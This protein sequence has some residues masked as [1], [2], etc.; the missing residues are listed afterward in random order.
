M[1][2]AAGERDA[3]SPVFGGAASDAWRDGARDDSRVRSSGVLVPVE[4]SRRFWLA[5]TCAT[6][7]SS[8]RSPMPDPVLA[9]GDGTLSDARDGAASDARD[10]AASD[11]RDGAASDARGDGAAFDARG[12][13]P[14]SDARGDGAA[15][16]PR[17]G[18]SSTSVSV[19][20]VGTSERS[21]T[22]SRVA[23]GKPSALGA[24]GGGRFH[25]GLVLPD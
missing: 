8:V 25:L 12:D 6:S 5:I 3:D 17:D 7:T 16:D 24:G 19:T 15:S 23:S 2:E 11:A 18:G 10:G 1:A 21:A 13:G 9:A 22:S 20:T 14:A 4:C